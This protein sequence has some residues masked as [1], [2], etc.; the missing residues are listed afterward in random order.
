M[1]YRVASALVVIVLALV[2]APLAAQASPRS[3]TL[4]EQI[5]HIAHEVVGRSEPHW[6][7]RRVLLNQ[8]A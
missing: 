7:P 2:V 8:A 4:V 6:I 5:E 3:Q 1:R